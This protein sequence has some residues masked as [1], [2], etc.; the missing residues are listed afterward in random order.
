MVDMACI[1]RFDVAKSRNGRSTSTSILVASAECESAMVSAAPVRVA[2]GTE[3][4]LLRPQ[5]NAPVAATRRPVHTPDQHLRA[6]VARA[7]AAPWHTALPSGPA[8]S[9]PLS[10]ACSGMARGQRPTCIQSA[11]A[12]F[13]RPTWRMRSFRIPTACAGCNCGCPV[14]STS[15]QQ[16]SNIKP[17]G[18]VREVVKLTSI[19]GYS[20]RSS[21]IATA[22][23]T[24]TC[25]K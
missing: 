18:A 12:V 4:M 9:A 23:P 24:E 25:D 6:I 3:K 10:S 17:R 20:V 14:F 15:K 5:R 22:K 7:F 2:H 1:S 21:A 19:A 8:P 13:S 11:I 16:I